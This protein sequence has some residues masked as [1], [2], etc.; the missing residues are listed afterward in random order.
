M[1]LAICMPKDTRNLTEY[2]RAV[3]QVGIG[4]QNKH[5]LWLHCQDHLAEQWGPTSCH[6]VTK[7]LSISI[8][9]AK[10]TLIK[11]QLHATYCFRRRLLSPVDM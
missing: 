8:W 11:P 1:F 9:T 10:T 5:H 7:P 3:H 2:L 4:D 6:V